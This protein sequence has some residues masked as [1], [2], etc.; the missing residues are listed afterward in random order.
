MRENKPSQSAFVIAFNMAGVSFEPGLR[1]LLSHPDEPYWHWFVSEHAPD[2]DRLLSAWKAGGDRGPG[3]LFRDKQVFA[4][5]RKRFIEDEV[6]QGLAEGVEQV[7][8]FGA[9]YD[10][11]SIRLAG[12]FPSVRFYE[13]DHPPTQA[14]KRRALESRQAIPPHLTLIPVDFALDSGEGALRGAPGFRPGASSVFVAEGVLMYLAPEDVD[15]LF[16]LVRRN[17]GPGS[18]FVSTFAEH[19][20]LTDSGT[21]LARLTAGL[22]QVGEPIRSTRNPDEIEGFLRDRGFSLRALADHRSLRATYMDPLKVDWPLRE[23]E[24][25]VVAAVLPA[26][27]AG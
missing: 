2:A 27:D 18:R 19:R 26:S 24:F 8:V 20:M 9:G 3:K 7:V 15:A 16:R 4:L 23:G 17:S 6:R 21:R 10:P 14:V 12:E 22:A 11:L 25:I 5:L 1:A 13:L